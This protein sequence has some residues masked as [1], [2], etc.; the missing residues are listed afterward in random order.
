MSGEDSNKCQQLV[1]RACPVSHMAPKSMHHTIRKFHE[2]LL[3][4]IQ[5]KT[6]TSSVKWS[7]KRNIDHRKGN[8]QAKSCPWRNKML[9]NKKN[10]N[11]CQDSL[12]DSRHF[13]NTIGQLGSN[14]INSL[15]KRLRFSAYSRLFRFESRLKNS[16]HVKLLV[17]FHGYNQKGKRLCWHC[18]PLW[19]I[20]SSK[21]Y[22]RHF[23]NEDPK[24][25]YSTT[26]LFQVTK[27]WLYP[28][29]WQEKGT[30]HPK[31]RGNNVHVLYFQ[32]YFFL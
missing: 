5:L 11:C 17:F 22:Q 16:D 27:K 19:E 8:F 6:T 13:K 32:T 14:W 23:S 28:S 20:A 7:A 21:A 25:V 30:D 1:L 3:I 15:V 26:S 10:L 12:M 31:N 4:F 9:Q 24:C 2:V 18:R 29:C